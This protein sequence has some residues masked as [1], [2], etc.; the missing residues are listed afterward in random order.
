[1]SGPN[2]PES[3][4]SDFGGQEPGSQPTQDHPAPPE[5]GETET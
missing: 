3:D 1:M 2:P 4:G 5:T